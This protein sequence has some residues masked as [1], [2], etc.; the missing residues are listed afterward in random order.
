MAS[1]ILTIED[2]DGIRRLI[3]MTLEYDGFAVAES[4]NGA[5]GI[6]MAKKV[7]PALILLDLK[8]PNLSGIEVCKILKSSTELRDIPVVMLSA[9][10]DQDGIAAALSAGA[11]RYLVKPFKPQQLLDLVSSLVKK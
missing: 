1:T 10:S 2:T 8:M 4:S 9:Q 5:D 11:L 7:K 6:E 3:R